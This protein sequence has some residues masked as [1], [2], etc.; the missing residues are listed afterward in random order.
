MHPY[1]TKSLEIRRSYVGNDTYVKERS[2]IALRII[3]DFYNAPY[4]E[5]DF[6]DETDLEY[7]RDIDMDNIIN[8]LTEG[9]GEWKYHPEKTNMHWDMDLPEYEEMC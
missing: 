7:F 3:C 1:G 9:R 6:I 2:A 5:K 8:F 4:N